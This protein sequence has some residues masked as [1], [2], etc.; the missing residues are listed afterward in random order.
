MGCPLN[1]E[2]VTILERE[3]HPFA[4]QLVENHSIVN[5]FYPHLASPCQPPVQAPASF[6]KCGETNGIDSEEDS[7]SR[8]IGPSLLCCRI[9]IHK[10]HILRRMI[11]DYCAAREIQE[12]FPG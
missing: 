2:L 12:L 1:I 9:E 6:H 3:P 10:D 5:T 11:T 4:N 8:K 7:F